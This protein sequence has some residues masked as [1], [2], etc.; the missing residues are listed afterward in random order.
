MPDP[1]TGR[2]QTGRALPAAPREMEAPLKAEASPRDRPPENVRVTVP[3]VAPPPVSVR[4]PDEPT[5]PRTSLKRV[6]NEALRLE[7]ARDVMNY[8][9]EQTRRLLPDVVD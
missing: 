5:E 4:T 1:L 7:T 2:R 8:L 9:R 6:A 3:R